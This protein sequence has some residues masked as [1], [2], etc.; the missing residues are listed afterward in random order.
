MKQS[1]FSIL[2]FIIIIL[3]IYYFIHVY[4]R[5]KQENF[6]VTWTPYVID[7]YHQPGYS[8]Y[9]YHNNYMYPVY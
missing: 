5:K 4:Q 7:N 2:F 6:E 1:Y 9:F 8:N 3:Y